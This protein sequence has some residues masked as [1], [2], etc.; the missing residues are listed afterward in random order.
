M[1]IKVQV[2]NNEGYS[3]GKYYIPQNEIEKLKTYLYRKIGQELVFLILGKTCMEADS[4]RP[5]N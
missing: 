4:F 5:W 2:L 3:C 1:I